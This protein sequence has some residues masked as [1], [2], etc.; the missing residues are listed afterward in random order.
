MARVLSRAQAELINAYLREHPDEHARVAADA[1]AL[2]LAQVPWTW[3]NEGLA[4]DLAICYC[5][6]PD[7]DTSGLVAAKRLRERGVVT[8]VVSQDLSRLRTV[9]PAS[10]Q[11]AGEFLG[12]TR[13]VGGRALL[14]L[15]PRAAV[16][17]GGLGRRRGVGA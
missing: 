5:F 14:R 2:G 12:R 17:R 9:D 6:P 3:V 4:R 13:V 11:M 8:D 10:L 15:G 7:L 16:R 1:T